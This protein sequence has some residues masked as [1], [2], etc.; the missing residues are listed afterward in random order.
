VVDWVEFAARM[1]LAAVVVLPAGMALL[2]AVRHWSRSAASALHPGLDRPE[3]AVLIGRA[4]SDRGR[5]RTG[6]QPR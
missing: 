2:W 5:R 1:T 3:A 6:R 4:T